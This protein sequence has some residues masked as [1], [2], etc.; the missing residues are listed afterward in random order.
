MI[1]FQVTCI[2]FRNQTCHNCCLPRF[3][4]KPIV[5][6]GS[7][8]QTNLV[9]MRNSA[10]GQSAPSLTASLVSTNKSLPKKTQNYGFQ[11]IQYMCTRDMSD[12]G[13]KDSESSYEGSR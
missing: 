3:K 12:M 6:P 7:V 9:R 10:L 13:T 5:C 8:E 4:P 2:Q 11:C 1:L